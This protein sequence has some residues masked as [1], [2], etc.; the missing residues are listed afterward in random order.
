MLLKCLVF[1]SE[2]NLCM[3]DAEESAAYV[4]TTMGGKQYLMLKEQAWKRL[5]DYYEALAQ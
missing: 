5:Q 2:E 1:Y 4:T 3:S